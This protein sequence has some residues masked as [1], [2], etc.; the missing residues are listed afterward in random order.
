M[1]NYELHEQGEAQGFPY[2]DL[3]TGI[4]IP[5]KKYL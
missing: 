4:I 5:V 3:F 1:L 2:R